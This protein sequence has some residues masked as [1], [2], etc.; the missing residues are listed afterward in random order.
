VIDLFVVDLD[1]ADLDS[2][3][4]VMSSSERC[5][6]DTILQP[7]RRQHWK[8]SRI[9]LRQILAERLRT[10]PHELKLT[11][12]GGKLSLKSSHSEPVPS[13]SLTRSDRF[14]CIAIRPDGPVGVD[15]EIHRTVR[16]REQKIVRFFCE[17]ERQQILALPDA[18]R[19]RAFLAVWTAKEALLKAVGCG[20]QSFPV[21]DVC[22]QL[23][24]VPI[25]CHVDPRFGVA[26]TWTLWSNI[27]DEQAT[28]SI[29][30]PG[31]GTTTAPEVRI[32]WFSPSECRLEDF[33]RC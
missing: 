33:S 14:C 9:A 2:Q 25:Y 1:D 12:S 27:I 32:R 7:G 6:A 24:E 28:C 20:V 8:R 23:G 21:T 29:A 26:V 11:E 4:Q 15:V 13:F 31:T 16:H 30:L 5:R 17:C 18:D 22:V 19:D 3:T 10:P